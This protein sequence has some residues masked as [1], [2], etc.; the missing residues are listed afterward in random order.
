MDFLKH[1]THSKYFK[2]GVII[3][4]LSMSTIVW[5]GCWVYSHYAISTN[6]AY[7]NANIVQISPRV[8]GKIS[9]LHIANNQY[10]KKGQPLFDIDEQP[11]QLAVHSAQAQLKLSH[12]EL[13]NALLTR[14]RVMTIV[15]KKF[16]SDQDGDNAT[17]NYKTAAAKLQQ[18]EANLEQANLNLEY[19]QITAPTS[20]WVTNMTTTVGEIVPANRPLFALISDEK[21][22]IDANFKE[23]ELQNIK[24]GQTAE[25]KTDLYPKYIF[26]GVVESISG[27][28]GSVFSLLP[29]QNATGNWVKITQRIPVRVNILNPD[30]A[31]PLRI[32]TSATVT[33]HF[34]NNLS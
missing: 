34:K 33:I 18:T 29:P 27:G 17:A 5:F 23:T 14:N 22:W 32:G 16:L 9:K 15:K 10:V 12:A 3:I 21:F 8:T 4:F 7:I 6:D 28:S 20:G 13:E 31:Y 24:P 19:T 30:A 11:F 26:K 2:A 25:I 1:I